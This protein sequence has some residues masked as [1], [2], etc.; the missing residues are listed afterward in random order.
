MIK[1][2]KA[3]KLTVKIYETREKMGAIAAQEAAEAIHSMLKEKAVLNIVFAAAPSQNEFLKNLAAKTNIDWQRITALHMDE[4]V[5]LPEDAP[6]GFGNFLRKAIFDKLPFGKIYYLYDNALSP[7]DNCRR[8]ETILFENPIDIVFMGIGENGHIA[9]NDPHV[10]YFNDPEKVKIVDLDLACRQQQVND[11]CF[12]SLD[13]V[14]THAV[15]LTI[16]VLM[17][18]KQIFCVV[19]SNRK[20]QAVKTTVEGKIETAC[21]ASI[22]RTHDNAVLY[23]DKEAASEL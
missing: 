21:P 13:D 4:Y 2:L 16:P 20:S 17:S 1:E 5:G 14:P 12:S 23:L 19:P 11:G 8:Y 22:L 15:T 9:F 10:A 18:A 7:E 6:Q 3:N